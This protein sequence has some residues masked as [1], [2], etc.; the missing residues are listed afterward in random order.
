VEHKKDNYEIITNCPICL[1]TEFVNFLECK[2]YTTSDK[3]FK[4]NKCNFCGFK[5][6]NPR[7]NED[8]MSYFYSSPSYISHTNT[9][10]GIINRLYKI[11][12]SITISKKISWI[13][14]ISPQGIL[15]D[16]GSGTGEF[17]NAL[18][19]KGWKT[20]G[21]EPYAVA[22]NFSIL[23]YQLNIFGPGE[24]NMLKTERFDVI[25]LW[26]VLEHIHGL[27]E[28]IIN[29]KGILNPEGKLI[30]AVPN[31]DAYDAKY[32]QSYWAAY[33]LPRHLYHFNTDTIEKLFLKHQLKVIKRFPM[34]LDVFYISMLSEKYKKHTFGILKG[35][36]TG[37]FFSIKTNWFKSGYS[38]Q[39]YVIEKIN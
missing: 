26:H 17:L 6:T 30:I 20:R 22:R 25:T 18:K 29:L 37:I 39:V 13:N 12:R 19:R 21:V 27:D 7:P 9:T 24:M 1:S 10:K 28:T 14:S 32:Y 23:N 16:Y 11:A 5:F 15:L 35:V 4:I 2:D 36:L 8:Q 34:I 31:S 38:S 3:F 33:D